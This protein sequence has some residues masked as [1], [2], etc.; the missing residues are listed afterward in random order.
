M[1]KIDPSLGFLEDLFESEPQGSYL[2]AS[3]IL[4][5][6]DRR[7]GELGS[8][9]PSGSYASSESLA[10]LA[11]REKCGRGG[12]RKGD[13]MDK[14]YSSSS[15][16]DGRCEGVD[17]SFVREV[18][19]GMDVGVLSCRGVKG[20]TCLSKEGV[21]GDDFALESK[22]SNLPPSLPTFSSAAY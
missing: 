19:E 13:G 15:E 4:R 18:A 3:P 21:V 8:G 14:S 10:A 5:S 20:Q 1:I 9:T 22:R 17:R 2:F 16:I 12:G 6:E 7:I 11:G